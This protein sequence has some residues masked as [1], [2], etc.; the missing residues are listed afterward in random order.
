MFLQFI[1]PRTTRRL[2]SCKFDILFELIYD[3]T[4]GTGKCEIQLQNFLL[5]ITPSNTPHIISLLPQRHNYRVG[6]ASMTKQTYHQ[7][8]DR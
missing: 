8:I 6:Q 7:Q 5:Q 4:R 2:G 3:L 1:Q